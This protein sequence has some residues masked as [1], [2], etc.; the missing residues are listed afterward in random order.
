MHF[1]YAFQLVVIQL[2]LQCWFLWGEVCTKYH[3]LIVFANVKNPKYTV[4]QNKVPTFELSV[5]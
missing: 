3:I 1:K 4:S 2:T 5:T